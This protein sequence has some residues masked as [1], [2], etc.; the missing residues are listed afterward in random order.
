MVVEKSVGAV[1]WNLDRRMHVR[2]PAV[3][4]RG[5]M[6]AG[7]HMWTDEPPA[8]ISICCFKIGGH[9][10]ARC[11]LRAGVGQKTTRS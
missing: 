4:E 3:V 6:E 2:I 5:L 11:N 1:Y 10:A 7:K 9:L 8:S